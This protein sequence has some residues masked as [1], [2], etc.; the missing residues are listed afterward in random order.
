MHRVLAA[1]EM[2]FPID[3][4]LPPILATL[5]GQA[6]HNALHVRA[7][8]LHQSEHLDEL[9]ASDENSLKFQQLAIHGIAPM[10]ND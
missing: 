2:R 5:L 3:N 6:G 1:G 4:A 9:L 7:I 10:L 8:D